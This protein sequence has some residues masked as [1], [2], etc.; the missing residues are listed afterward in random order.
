VRG[1]PTR[2]RELLQKKAH[3]SLSEGNIWIDFGIRALKIDMCHNARTTMPGPTHEER[4]QAPVLDHA[5]HVR[6]REV[7]A[8]DCPPV[9][10]ES[11]LDVLMLQW[12]LQTRIVTAQ[13]DLAHCEVVGG[14]PV[15]V[16]EANVLVRQGCRSVAHD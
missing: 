11:R 3:T 15:R 6:V 8:R 5:I 12:S 13:V 7:D 9:A 4:I 10:K 16:D 1:D 14:A 2:P